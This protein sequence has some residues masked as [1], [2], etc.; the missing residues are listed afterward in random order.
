M[1]QMSKNKIA[2]WKRLLKKKYPGVKIPITCEFC[3][4]V[5]GEPWHC[6][7]PD[8]VLGINVWKDDCCK[9]WFLNE[10]L[11]LYVYAKYVHDLFHRE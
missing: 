3:K 8:S 1:K 10:G 9:E 5:G 2:D 11:C 6:H 4:W 7:N